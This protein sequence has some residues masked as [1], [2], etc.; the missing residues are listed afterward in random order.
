[1]VL[2]LD[3]TSDQVRVGLAQYNDNIYPAFQLNQYPLKSVVL[4]Q[5]QNLPYRTGDTNIGSALE[6][7]RIRYLTE[8]VVSRAKDRVP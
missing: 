2:G 4:E 3:I 8:A 6:F 5:I 1:M 7:M